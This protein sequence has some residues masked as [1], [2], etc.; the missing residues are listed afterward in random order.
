MK[1][2]FICEPIRESKTVR[3]NPETD[4][5]ELTPEYKRLIRI[6]NSNKQILEMAKAVA[7]DYK[8]KMII[9][10]SVCVVEPI[11][12]EQVDIVIKSWNDI[13]EYMPI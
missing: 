1:K 6:S 2:I 13:G 4:S 7:Q 9:Y 3:Y 5:E 11:I 12:P 10:E 8:I